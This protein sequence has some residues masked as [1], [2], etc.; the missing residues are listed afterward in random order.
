MCPT[1]RADASTGLFVGSRRIL[2]VSAES[3][4]STARYR[5]TKP[6]QDAFWGESLGATDFPDEWDQEK[7]KRDNRF[8]RDIPPR[9]GCVCEK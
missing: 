4:V 1:K 5:A 3:F 7:K 8:A 9:R 6:F 2:D